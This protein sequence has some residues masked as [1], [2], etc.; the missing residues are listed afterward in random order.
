[1]SLLMFAGDSDAFSARDAFVRT[2]R[3]VA[4]LLWCPSICLSG[5]G[6]HCDH[7]VQVSADLSLWLDNPMF[8]A[9]WQQSIST[10]S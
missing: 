7:M 6:M 1:M 2:S 9:P 3:V 5:T 4:L 8:W 10:Y